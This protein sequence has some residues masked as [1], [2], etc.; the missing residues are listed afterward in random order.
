MNDPQ[1]D[2]VKRLYWLICSQKL[3]DGSDGAKMAEN[4]EGIVGRRF[5]NT[6]EFHYLVEK[7]LKKHEDSKQ[8]V[9]AEVKAKRKR[10]GFTQAELATVLGASK[11]TVINYELNQTPPSKRLLAWLSEE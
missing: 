6:A 9:G 5:R 8:T 2:D 1:V 11:R 10:L 4:L 3:T 7:Y